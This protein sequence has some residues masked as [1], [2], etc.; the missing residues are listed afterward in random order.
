MRKNLHSWLFASALALGGLFGETQAQ[1]YYYSPSVRTAVPQQRVIVGTPNRV[2][3]NNGVQYQSF[4]PSYGQSHVYTN[5]G[6]YVQP[7]QHYSQ[8]APSYYSQPS[9]G[10]YNNYPYSPPIYSGN[11]VY[12]TQPSGVY[13]SNYGS[14]FYSSPQQAGNANAGAIIGGAIGGQQG[15]RVGAAIGAGIRP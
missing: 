6:Y 15:A 9:N 3:S 7:H 8:N 1:V 14:G 5:N 12:S 13:G 2:Y 11:Q 10:Y 4:R